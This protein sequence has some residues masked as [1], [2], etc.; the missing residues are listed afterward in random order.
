[1]HKTACLDA[2][3][4][5]SYQARTTRWQ[6]LVLDPAIPAR[7]RDRLPAL[8]GQPAF[9]P[10]GITHARISR[11]K[12]LRQGAISCLTM[13]SGHEYRYVLA[14]ALTTLRRRQIVGMWFREVIQVGAKLGLKFSREYPTDDYLARGIGIL[15]VQGINPEKW[16]TGWNHYMVLYRGLYFSTDLCVYT[17]A[18]WKMCYPE[19]SFRAL[20][21]LE[22][23]CSE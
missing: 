7:R 20:L 6:D 17:P 13:L 3:G 19:A 16:Q 18:E 5:N 11:R 9:A 10:P 14:L 1:M 23:R 12:A 22:G 4:V 15:S 2:L 8:D 21:R